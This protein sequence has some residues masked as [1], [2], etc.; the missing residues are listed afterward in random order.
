MGGAHR[1]S[2]FIARQNLVCIYLSETISGAESGEEAPMSNR[3]PF[4]S[5]LTDADVHH[6]RDDCTIGDNIQPWNVV[7]GDGGLP[8]CKRCRMLGLTEANGVGIRNPLLGLAPV[9]PIP[10]ALGPLPMSRRRF[11][12]DPL[13]GLDEPL[14]TG[15]LPFGRTRTGR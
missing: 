1:R 5:I 15:A 9:G 4:R 7:R 12:H 14:V 11:E 2:A 8:L 10:G 3:Y 6:N 13:L